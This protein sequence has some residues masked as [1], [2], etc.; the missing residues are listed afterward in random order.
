MTNMTMYNTT[1]HDFS[2][3]II[4]NGDLLKKEIEL[5]EENS[6]SFSDVNE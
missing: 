6:F 4:N 1:K 3:Y 5:P 2:S